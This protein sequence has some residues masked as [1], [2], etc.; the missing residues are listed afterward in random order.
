MLGLEA[1]GVGGGEDPHL[2]LHPVAAAAPLEIGGELEID[3]AQMGDVGDGI[4]ELRL[5]QRPP[6]PVGKAVRLVEIIA[7]DALH[8]LVI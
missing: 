6:R 3:I 1:I 8:Q 5:A 2:L 7:G 4:G